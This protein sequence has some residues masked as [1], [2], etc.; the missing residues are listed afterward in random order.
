[1]KDILLIIGNGLAMDF[2][3]TF[4]TPLHPSKPLTWDFSIEQEKNK[5][6]WQEAFPIFFRYVSDNLGRLNNDNFKLFEEIKLKK[7]CNLE[8]EARHFLALAYTYQDHSKN[9][10]LAWRKWRWSKFIR[11]EYH[12]INNVISFNYDTTI[13]ELIHNKGG[14][15]IPSNGHYRLNGYA[16]DVITIFKPHGCRTLDI[17]DNIIK[18]GD[19]K[20][21]P[22][23]LFFLH[24]NAHEKQLSKDDQKRAR[25]SSLCILPYE[26]NLYQD[27]RTQSHM[28]ENLKDRNTT[29]KYCVIIGHSYGDADKKEI[30]TILES[31]PK[32]A[33]AHVCDPNPNMA[34]IE[35]LNIL[36]IKNFTH[37]D[38]INT[39][40]LD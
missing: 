30:D 19:M 31:L 29:I 12:R 23:S 5:I 16:E 25:V 21:Y 36:G 38:K 3:V 18:I 11:K 6:S 27:F 15:L 4:K 1:M 40:Q 10:P 14:S 8:V 33:I 37:T 20:K 17:A 35:K 9:S 28:W 32:N 2:H 24:T 7:D 26:E 39:P 22:M 34:L 13:E